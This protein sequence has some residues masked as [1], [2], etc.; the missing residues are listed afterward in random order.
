M[1]QHTSRH[2]QQQIELVRLFFMVLFAAISS[3]LKKQIHVFNERT[4]QWARPGGGQDDERISTSTW[5]IRIR[6]H[7]YEKKEPR[8]IVAK[9]GERVN[10]TSSVLA[11][12]K[13]GSLENESTS[14]HGL[15]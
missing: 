6:G 7:R 8:L 9:R 3:I 15:E 2:Q 12:S 14:Q 1:N 10:M 4:D 11:E 13:K 5:L